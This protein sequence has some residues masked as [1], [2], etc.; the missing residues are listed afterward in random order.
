MTNFN[1]S[2]DLEHLADLIRKRNEN[3]VAI[4]RVIDRPALLGHIGE[5]IASQV[6]NIALAPNA[7][8]PRIDGW[9]RSPALAGKSVDVKTYAKREG[10]LDNQ[11]GTTPGLLLGPYRSQVLGGFL[12]R[13]CSSM[14]HQ[15][16]VPV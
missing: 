12:A 15:R 14:G 2:T 3:E 10:V 7:A 9:F 11:A 8:N 5:Y 4:T 13:N 16:S 6:F 1:G